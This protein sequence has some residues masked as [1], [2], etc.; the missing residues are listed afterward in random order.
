[1]DELVHRPSS[2]AVL[3]PSS[4]VS[5]HS[6]LDNRCGHG[7]VEGEEVEE[8]EVK[9]VKRFGDVRWIKEVR[10]HGR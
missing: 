6:A 8:V 10:R 1:M 2:T 3:H 5:V 9:R 4:T 7:G